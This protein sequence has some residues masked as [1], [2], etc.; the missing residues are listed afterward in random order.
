MQQIKFRV[1]D[2]ERKIIEE[3]GAIDW[4]DDGLPITV[5]TETRKLYRTVPESDF[6]LMRFIGFKDQKGVEIYE[7]DIVK[8]E[9]ENQDQWTGIGVGEMFWNRQVTG[10]SIKEPSGLIAFF[11]PYLGIYEGTIE[12]IGNIY[13]NPE[14]LKNT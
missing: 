5:N 13:E 14:L 9:V 10:F 6:V 3:V 4:A 11:R 1:W 12:V 2:T 8:F 7:G